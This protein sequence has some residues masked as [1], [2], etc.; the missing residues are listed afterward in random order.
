MLGKLNP[1]VQA[2]SFFL[3]CVRHGEIQFQFIYFQEFEFIFEL[4]IFEL[5][6]FVL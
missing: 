6:I 1:A 4:L 3:P 2:S 5:F